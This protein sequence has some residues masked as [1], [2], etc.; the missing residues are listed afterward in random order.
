MKSAKREEQWNEARKRCRLSDEEVGM[1]R[2]MGLNP[3]SLIKNIPSPSQRWKAPVSQWIRRMYA[4]RGPRRT[5]QQKGLDPAS[6]LDE[7]FADHGSLGSRDIASEN[8]RM[9]RRQREFRLAAEYV[10][11]AFSALPEVMRVVLI[12]SVAVPLRKEMPRFREYRRAG[13]AIWHE[14]ADVDLAVWLSRL[15][16]LNELRRARS[17]ALNDLLA[18]TEIGVAH[19]QVDVF[20]LEPATNRYLGRLCSF[21]AC[22]KNKPE[23]RVPGC[24]AAPFLRQHPDFSW[25]AESLDPRRTVILFERSAAPPGEEDC[26][27]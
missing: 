13:V 23:C 25:R 20:V 11:G 16:R 8:A 12:G 5:A 3:L 24:G 6:G 18:E 7:I 22:P 9:L 14:C 4:R 1:A 26:P 19:H 10:A 21:G 2:E 15:D 17:R 27:F